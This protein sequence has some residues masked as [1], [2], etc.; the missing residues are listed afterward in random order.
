MVFLKKAVSEIQPCVLDQ[1]E[2]IIYSKDKNIT[3]L[4]WTTNF[5]LFKASSFFFHS[6]WKKNSYGTVTSGYLNVGIEGF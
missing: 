6:H 2:K 1:P 3:N 4:I 5:F